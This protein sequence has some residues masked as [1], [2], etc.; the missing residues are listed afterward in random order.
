LRYCRRKSRRV[1]KN[2]CRWQTR[3][4]CCP[5]KLGLAHRRLLRPS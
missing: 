5:A 2:C 4:S 3:R 1:Q